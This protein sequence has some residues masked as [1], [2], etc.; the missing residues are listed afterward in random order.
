MKYHNWIQIVI[1]YHAFNIFSKLQFKT[2]CLT[3]NN[4]THIADSTTCYQQILTQHLNPAD[5][6]I[7]NNLPIP[8]STCVE[9]KSVLTVLQANPHLSHSWRN[10]CLEQNI[11]QLEYF[12]EIYNFSLIL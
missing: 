8:Q 2:A 6:S 7:C 9:L 1:S 10:Y 5:N 3:S 11:R 4:I 12:V